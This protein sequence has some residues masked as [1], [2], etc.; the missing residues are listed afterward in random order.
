M[1]WIVEMLDQNTVIWWNQTGKQIQKRI[2][3][4]ILFKI[5]IMSSKYK[6]ILYKYQKQKSIVQRILIILGKYLISLK[7]NN[8]K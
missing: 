4:A 7:I 6:T 8:L 2:G 5:E 3:N 1:I